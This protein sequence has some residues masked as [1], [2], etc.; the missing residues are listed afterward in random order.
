[1][2]IKSDLVAFDR[3][4]AARI[5]RVVKLVEGTPKN[6]L[7]KHRPRPAALPR[8]RW[9]GITAVCPEF[10][11]YPTLP[12]DTYVIQ[13]RERRYTEV[14]GNQDYIDIDHQTY[15][16]A[17]LAALEGERGAFPEG[18]EVECWKL[19]TRQGWRWWFRPLSDGL[20]GGCLAEN[21]PGRGEPFLIHLGVWSSALNR[22]V[23]DEQ[24]TV[25]AIDWRYGVPF[26]DAGSTGLFEARPSDLYGTVWEAVSL[27]CSSPG[28]CYYYY[29]YYGGYYGD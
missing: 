29:G 26:P 17:H 25:R 27:D 14:P 22:W 4:S 13:L 28:S 2:P 23:Y 20:I 9:F 10:P 24:T 18:T 1:M 3:K 19:P 16:V 5:S 6:Q 8:D 7:P 11:T 21:H 15:V 12:A